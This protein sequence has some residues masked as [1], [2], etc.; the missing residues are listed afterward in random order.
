[1]GFS[2]PELQINSATTLRVRIVEQDPAKPNDPNAFVP[3]SIPAGSAMTIYVRPPGAAASTKA[4]AAVFTTDGQ[5]G[6]IEYSPEVGEAPPIDEAGKWEIQGR[7]IIAGKAYWSRRAAFR[8]GANLAE[9]GAITVV[10]GT[11]AG[12][13]DVLSTVIV[14]TN[15]T[16]LADPV[17]G[18]GFVL[19][20]TLMISGTF[21]YTDFEDPVDGVDLVYYIDAT[22][23]DDGNDGL[24]P[25]QAWQTGA[26]VEPAIR[27]GYS[28]RFY[29]L[30]G[31]TWVGPGFSFNNVKLIGRSASQPI[32]FGYYG[33]NNDPRPKFETTGGSGF[34]V[35]GNSGSELAYFAMVGLHFENVSTTETNAD[36]FRFN[37][38]GV[39]SSPNAPNAVYGATYCLV[40]D[41][42]FDSYCNNLT[43]D[44]QGDNVGAFFDV[45]L[46]RNLIVNSYRY[47]PDLTLTDNRS[48]GAFIGQTTG[49]LLE[50]NYYDHNGWIESQVLLVGGVPNTPY[51]NLNHNVYTT[52]KCRNVVTRWDFCLRAGGPAMQHR[53]GGTLHESFFQDNPNHYTNGVVRGGSE[54]VVPEG[55]TCDV[56]RNVFLKANAGQGDGNYKGIEFA[57][58][59]SAPSTVQDNIVA[60]T[61]PL[62]P[63]QTEGTGQAKRAI[64]LEPDI[65][66]EVD[67]GISDFS[68]IDNLF[69]NAGYIQIDGEQE[70]LKATGS[71]TFTGTDGG[72]IPSGAVLT[73]GDGELYETT[74]GGVIAGGTVTLTV[75]AQVAGYDGNTGNGTTLTLT[76]PITDV[77]DDATAAGPI[78]GGVWDNVFDNMLMQGNVVAITEDIGDTSGHSNR[79]VRTRNGSPL[80]TIT[81][82]F[83]FT[84]N[85]YY[86]S[87]EVGGG[88]SGDYFRFDET[89]NYTVGDWRTNVEPSAIFPGID[90]GVPAPSY[91][92][93][94]RDLE[95]Y[96]DS[97]L[98]G[99]APWSLDSIQTY[100]LTLHRH[101]WPADVTAPKAVDY[102]RGGFDLPLIAAL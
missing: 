41:C 87:E 58:Q 45:R 77:D 44:P 11:I 22:N 24:S 89:G 2:N 46:R 85:S 92:D 33:D 28:D 88:N 74:Q 63:G 78:N 61:A 65:Q 72:T 76:T 60:H 4:L 40:E 25:G 99:G 51:D 14:S 53:S 29:F 37:G 36:G 12:V 71:V 30:R 96:F 34:D 69:Y 19:M 3:V 93:P 94:D 27:Q 31:E 62:Y 101:N 50:G 67:L 84:G 6:L 49:V 98:P 66:G 17:A 15:L 8:A 16:M 48:Q 39:N 68:L 57:N 7:V 102:V 95:Q 56:Q 82:K 42:C 86:V 64:N 59:A 43:F 1:M 75:E 70:A 47:N 52:S 20:P 23:G 97:I 55:V 5:D 32:V 91:T 54:P 38:S 100:M 81:G 79:A 26:N 18:S 83:T 9:S 35:F 80:A 13:G 73:R 21:S 90:G 10:P